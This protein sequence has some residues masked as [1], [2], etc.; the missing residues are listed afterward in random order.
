[1]KINFMRM[2]LTCLGLIALGGSSFSATF[3]QEPDVPQFG[4]APSKWRRVA[5]L[6]RLIPKWVRAL[7]TLHFP[8]D[9]MSEA[10]AKLQRSVAATKAAR[11]K[12]QLN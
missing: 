9:K 11:E 5:I 1:M 4:A 8:P 3:S 2:R 6:K 7:C 12:L 10:H